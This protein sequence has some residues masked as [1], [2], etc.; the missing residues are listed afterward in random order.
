MPT[1]RREITIPRLSVP[2]MPSPDGLS[3]GIIL[4]ERKVEFGWRSKLWSPPKLIPPCKSCGNTEV[5]HICVPDAINALAFFLNLRLTDG[6][7]RG[8]Q[9]RPINWIADL[10]PWLFGMKMYDKGAMTPGHYRL[11][12]ELVLSITRGGM[13]STFLEALICYFLWAFPDGS[14]GMFA[15]QNKQETIA[16]MVRKYWT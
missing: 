5:Y 9:L 4:P 16:R 6:T 1:D 10:I 3:K 7:F 14:E 15:Q 2:D 8:H 12:Q 11:I 13:K